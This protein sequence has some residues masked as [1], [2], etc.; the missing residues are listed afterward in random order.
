MHF[1]LCKNK[2]YIFHRYYTR[3]IGRDVTIK[4]CKNCGKKIFIKRNGVG[5]AYT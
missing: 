5:G 1:S 3:S 2:S 4:V